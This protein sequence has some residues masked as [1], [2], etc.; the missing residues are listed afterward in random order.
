M[1]HCFAVGVQVEELCKALN[2]QN[3]IAAVPSVLGPVFVYF[4]R[5]NTLGGSFSGLAASEQDK[6]SAGYIPTDQRL[7]SSRNLVTLSAP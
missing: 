1:E 5:L 4:H 2:R 3:P 6:G 7:T